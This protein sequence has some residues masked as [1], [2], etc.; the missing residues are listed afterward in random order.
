MGGLREPFQVQ[1]M[2]THTVRAQGT[3][4][5]QHWTVVRSDAR[6]CH[7][8][9][10]PQEFRYEVYVLR[11]ARLTEIGDGRPRGWARSSAGT[12]TSSVLPLSLPLAVSESKY[13][14]PERARKL[15]RPHGSVTLQNVT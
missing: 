5:S 10:L 12:P 1:E 6:L 2:G 8:P 7:L 14:F 3:W 4:L 11:V 13:G 9:S 15:G